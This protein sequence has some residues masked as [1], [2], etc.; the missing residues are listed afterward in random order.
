MVLDDLI[1]SLI[2]CVREAVND[3]HSHLDNRVNGVKDKVGYIVI[4][5]NSHPVGSYKSLVFDQV[6]PTLWWMLS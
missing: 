4:E 3:P 5:R 1:P 2:Y 6:N